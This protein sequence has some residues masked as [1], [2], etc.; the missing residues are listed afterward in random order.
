MNEVKNVLI[1]QVL[2]SLVAGVLGIALPLMMDQRQIDVK[3]VGVIFA[4]M[5]LIMQG[6][7]LIFAT[8]SD[9]WGRKL[10]F[11]SNGLL[12]ILSAL[13]YYFARTP[14][15]FVFG[16]TVEG[17]KEGTL[18]AVNR[19][20]L[21][22]KG[23]GHWKILVYLRAIVYVAYAVGSLLAGFF[24]VWLLFEGTMLIC[25]LISVP[26]FL[27]ALLLIGQKREQ[28]S[29]EKVLRFLDFRQKDKKFKIFLFLFFC[30]GSAFGL[31]GG[32]VIPYF[33][34]A[35]SFSPEAIGAIICLQILM[36]GL[37]SYLC[38][39]TSRM[40]FLTLL[41]GVLF[42][43]IFALLG[44]S[45]FLL[46]GVL[47]IASGA[48]EGMTVI[49]QEGI[50]SKICTKESYGTDIG[51]LMT[52]LHIGEAMSLA[53]AGILIETLGYVAPF[54]LSAVIYAIFYVGSYL[55]LKE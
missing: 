7:R 9:F 46:A 27:L 29:K 14:L 49:G 37:F 26:V 54:L 50:L 18:W 6:G 45:S 11:V 34:K 13:V 53:L 8:V 1:I 16:K 47:I 15:E 20:F 28:V 17:T 30:W 19:A 43:A 38:S 41:S 10:F 33:L 4:C 2:N 31:I 5:P 24:I 52:G 40:R 12:G 42:S 3:L 25:A 55:N 48:V 51:L 44:F 32:F 22:E 23:K 36:A 39:R 21:L 35:N